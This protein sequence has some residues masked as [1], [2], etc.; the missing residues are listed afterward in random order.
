VT[1]VARLGGELIAWL[2]RSI[3]TAIGINVRAWCYPRVLKRGGRGLR[4]AEHVYIE[5]F[6]HLELGDGV[7]I[8]PFTYIGTFAG[9][10]TVGDRTSIN[11]NVQLGANQGR[12]SIGRSVLIG[13]NC[14]LRAADHAFADPQRPIAE[15][16]HQDGEIIIEDD[17]WLAANVVVTRNVRI[18]R[19]AI[20]AA[21][22]VVTKDVAP[23]D[24]VGGVPA[25][26]IG[27]RGVAVR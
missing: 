19:G 23:F 17:V 21:G 3:P 10:C 20:V 4:I 24:I 5:G 6:S 2:A 22:A 26:V 1:S 12:I 8:M 16:G 15:Q 27:S 7:S 14:V 9:V 13:P 11:R 25:R 18:G